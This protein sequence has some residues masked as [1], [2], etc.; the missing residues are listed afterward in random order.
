MSRPESLF[1]SEIRKAYV[2]TDKEEIE[3][4]V[5]KLREA[6]VKVAS[7]ELKTNLSYKGGVRRDV[8]VYFSSKLDMWYFF[9]YQPSVKYIHA[10]GLGWPRSMVSAIVEVNFPVKGRSHRVAGA[11]IKDSVGMT[12]VAHNGKIGGAKRGVG[13]KAFWRFYKGDCI[14]LWEGGAKR[15]F[16]LIGYLSSDELPVRIKRFVLMVNAIKSQAASSLAHF[17][18]FSTK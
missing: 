17:Q 12:W 3:F 6:L 7:K 18:L 5:N 9:G 13:L 10:F 8:N 2:V 16:A 4:S 1:C 15:R 11:F 14:D